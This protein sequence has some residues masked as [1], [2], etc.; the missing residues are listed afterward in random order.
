MST[1]PDIKLKRSL[2][3]GKIPT[4]EQLGIGELAINHYDGKLFVRQDTQG[5][6]IGT[7]VIVANPWSVGVGSNTYNTYFTN[8]NVG[9]GTTNP[10]S[11]LHVI[12]DGLV[13][14]MVTATSFSGN[15]VGTATTA[16]NLADAANI[17]TGTVSSARLSGTYNINISGSSAYATSS[18][19]STYATNSGIATY[20]TSSGISTNVI[21][22]IA[23]V[24]QLS[25]SG[26]TTLGVTS[27]TNLT[28]QQLNVSGL[29]TFAGI[30]TYTNSLFGTQASFTG[31]VTASSFVGTF[32][33]NIS[34]ANYSTTSGIA[35]SVIGGI[36][37]ITQLQV[38]GISTFT[39]GPVLVGVGSSTGTASQPLQITGGAYVSGNVGIGTTNPVT[40][41][42]VNGP[43]STN[44]SP[45][46][47]L[48]VDCSLGNYFTKTI[49]TA[50]T[51]TFS[52][53]PASRA[54]AFTME[55]THTS[56][57]VTWPTSV[58]WQYDTTPSLTTSRTHLFMFVTDDGGTRWRG[59][60]LIN[61]VN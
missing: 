10:T 13:V 7:T 38:T 46:S 17:T 20:A 15:L 3:A 1:T 34:N 57:A 14:G 47:V 36:G 53:P 37:S 60:S 51:F 33:G 21:G 43:H 6:G 8:G 59:A 35:T 26:I 24:T 61:Y 23:S 19:I 45:I 32:S 44:I 48:D 9:V 42:D 49:S 28:T 55:L 58:K 41:L 4:T 18:G 39:N 40:K 16:T 56:G 5:V 2:V 54:Y 31:V 30:T 50:S 12:G 11:K 52:N 25:V 29:S 27:T 22:G